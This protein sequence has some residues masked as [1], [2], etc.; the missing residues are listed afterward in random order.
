MRSGASGTTP[1]TDRATNFTTALVL[2]G[3][4]RTAATSLAEPAWTGDTN[5]IRKPTQATRQVSKNHTLAKLI[6]IISEVRI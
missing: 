6:F 5:T 3:S 2:F 1:Q 4:D